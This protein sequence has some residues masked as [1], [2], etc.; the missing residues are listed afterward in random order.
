MKRCLAEMERFRDL[1]CTA[2]RRAEARPPN[3]PGDLGGGASG[4]FGV[5]EL[6]RNQL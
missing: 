4:L 6:H 1:A 2:S 3:N 5:V